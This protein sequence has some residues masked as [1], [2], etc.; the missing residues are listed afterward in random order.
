[1]RIHYKLA[2]LECSSIN[3]TMRPHQLERGYLVLIPTDVWYCHNV[4][5]RATTHGGCVINVYHPKPRS[6]I[7]S[8]PIALRSTPFQTWSCVI[9]GSIDSFEYAFLKES[10]TGNFLLSHTTKSHQQSFWNLKTRYPLNHKDIQ[11]FISKTIW[12]INSQGHS[13]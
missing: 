3:L 12:K 10:Y 2:L 11:R 5:P 13:H 7:H 4:F 1:M 8:K 6:G 9:H